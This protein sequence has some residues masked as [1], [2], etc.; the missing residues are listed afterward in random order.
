MRCAA[1]RAH[2]SDWTLLFRFGSVQSIVSFVVSAV[3]AAAHPAVPASVRRKLLHATL[4][5]LQQRYLQSQHDQKTAVDVSD[6]STR[7]D[8][9][10]DDGERFPIF[11]RCHRPADAPPAHARRSRDKLRASHHFERSV[12]ALVHATLFGASRDRSGSLKSLKRLLDNSMAKPALS[13]LLAVRNDDHSGDFRQRVQSFLFN[14]AANAHLLDVEIV[15]VDWNSPN[16][17]L[18]AERLRIPSA[19]AG[20]VRVVHVPPDVHR[21]ISNHHRIDLFEY[22]AKNVGAR[23]SRAPFLVV[24]N[25]DSIW[26]NDVWTFLADNHDRLR[27]DA[28]YRACKIE[29]DYVRDGCGSNFRKAD[30]TCMSREPVTE[31][32]WQVIE[33]HIFPEMRFYCK[34]TYPDAFV[35]PNA[36]PYYD[37]AAGDFLLVHRSVYFEGNG[38]YEGPFNTAGDD[39]TQYRIGCQLREGNVRMLDQI[40][41]QGDVYHQR[42]PESGRFWHERLDGV[43]YEFHEMLC[44]SHCVFPRD[45]KFDNSETWGLPDTWFAEY[46]F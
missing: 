5:E 23:R 6:G 18:L 34:A 35:S 42:H 20:R 7:Y 39:I 1:T 22:T 32:E 27:I 9:A 25:A 30:G 43:G 12:L 26:S 40:I 21:T 41:L 45:V 44:T 16:S 3:H 31:V 8:R 24:A 29:M 15:M 28:L 36:M 10:L 4:A 37:G 19:L 33:K 38:S 11:S 13:V 14:Q 2:R 46:I 17:S